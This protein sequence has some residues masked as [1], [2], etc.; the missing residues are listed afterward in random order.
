MKSC[1]GCMYITYVCTYIWYIPILTTCGCITHYIFPNRCTNCRNLGFDI[2]LTSAVLIVII[3]LQAVLSCTLY[4]VLETVSISERCADQRASTYI[5]TYNLIIR[6]LYCK[7]CSHKSQWS[8]PGWEMCQSNNNDGINIF[9]CYVLSYI[10]KKVSLKNMHSFF[11]LLLTYPTTSSTTPLPPKKSPNS[12]CQYTTSSSLTTCQNP[13]KSPSP[14]SPEFSP[15][16]P[17]LK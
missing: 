7:V 14:T 15:P 5:H 16:T 10:K 9:K 8:C 3:P 6:K 17:A 13:P 2:Y 11:N 12:T 4:S 1:M